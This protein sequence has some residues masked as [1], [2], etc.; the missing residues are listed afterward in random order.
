MC[1]TKHD[2]LTCLASGGKW[3]TMGP[4]V[5][6]DPPDSQ[7]LHWKCASVCFSNQYVWALAGSQQG[8]LLHILADIVKMVAKGVVLPNNIETVSID[9]LR[10]EDTVGVAGG[11]RVMVNP[12]NSIHGST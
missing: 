6:L 12:P 9:S 8:R 10:I 4:D 7:L 11:V 3:V 1:P 2:I 5:Q